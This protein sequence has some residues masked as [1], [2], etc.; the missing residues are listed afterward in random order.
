MCSFPP[1]GWIQENAGSTAT[2]EAV[3]AGKRSVEETKL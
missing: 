1:A 3:D 2:G